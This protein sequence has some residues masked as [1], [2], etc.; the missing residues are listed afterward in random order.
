MNK[1][2]L[3]KK[4]VST[5]TKVIIIS[6]IIY[7][8]IVSITILLYSKDYISIVALLSIIAVPF[9]IGLIIYVLYYI[10]RKL[11]LRNSIDNKNEQKLNSS[12]VENWSR[13][14]FREHYATEIE[15]INNRSRLVGS[16]KE[17]T[18]VSILKIY[19]LTTYKYYLF[20][21][22]LT[23]PE[24]KN[25]VLDDIHSE[26]D[27]ER[28]MIHLAYSL[29]YKPKRIVERETLEGTK[30]REEEELPEFDEVE[31]DKKK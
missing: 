5:I 22:N 30:V 2:E 11:E 19:G 29:P 18:P 21:V 28:E 7:I 25:T 8:I 23:D 27:I 10:N 14:Y 9:I 26:S 13:K 20:L 4:E 24:G 15:I 6:L 16:N 12:T 17:L 3:P 1:D 31:D